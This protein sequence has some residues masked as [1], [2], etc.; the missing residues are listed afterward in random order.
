MRNI[1]VIWLDPTDQP[2]VHIS[3]V[4]GSEANAQIPLDKVDAYSVT[5]ASYDPAA[6]HKLARSLDEAAVRLS[7]AIDARVG[8]D[9]AGV[10]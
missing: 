3:D 10:A 9:M 7:A 2:K 5:L 1:Q 8:R 4:D 6:L